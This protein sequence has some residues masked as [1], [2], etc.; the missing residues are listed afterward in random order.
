[1]NKAKF[2]KGQLHPRNKHQSRYDFPALV[3]ACP[4]LSK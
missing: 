2:K 1:M 4:E 3:K